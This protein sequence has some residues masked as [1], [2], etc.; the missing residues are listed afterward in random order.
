MTVSHT[1]HEMS[2][3]VCLPVMSI[4]TSFFPTETFTTLVNKYA[5]PCLPWKV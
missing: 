1:L 2:A 4:R 3:T 5:R